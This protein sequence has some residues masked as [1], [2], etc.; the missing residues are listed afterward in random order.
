M[1]SMLK[2]I[3]I[4]ITSSLSH[5]PKNHI[6]Y[7]KSRNRF[8]FFKQPRTTC[9]QYSRLDFYSRATV[10]RSVTQN[11][12]AKICNFCQMG[13]LRNAMELLT[14]SQRHEIGLSTYYSVLQLCA[15]K[16]SLEDGKRVHSII[17]SNGVVIDEVLGAKLVFM[18][19]KCGDLVNAR[20]IFDEILNDNV[21][22]WNLMM[23]GYAKIDYYRE[24]L[25]LFKKMQ[26]MG[27]SGDSY[28]FTCVL[29]CFAELRKVKECKSVQGY[30]L[31]L[32]FGSNTAV[33]NSMIAAYFK[34][35]EVESA[36]NLFD[37]LT[38]R[39]VVSWNSLIS[40]CVVKG[41][42]GNGL[43]I[44]VEMLVMGVNWNLTTLVSVLDASTNIGNLSF[45][46]A[47]HAFGVK[48]CYG[49]EF[50][51]NNE[52]LY[53]YAIGGDLVNAR[54]IFD[55]ILNDKVSLWNFM[56][57]EYAKSGYY[58]ESLSLFKKMQKMGVSGDSNTFTCVLKCFAALRK[59]KECKRVHEYILKLGFGSNTAVVTSMIAAYFKFGEVESALN[60][61]DE[62]TD[63]DVVSW[64]SV[65]S[66]CAVNGFSKNVVE[67][68][69]Q[70]L[71]MGVNW[72]LNTLVSVLDASANIG[73]LSIGRALHAF[74]VKA[75]FGEEF[76]FNNRLL[77]MYSKIRDYRG[78]LSLFK[79]MQMMGVLG[80]SDMFCCAFKCFAELGKLEECKRVHGYILK[81]GFGSNTAVVNSMIV[82][83]FKF[84]EVESACNLFDELTDRD[85]FSW[86]SMINGCIMN[87]L[88][89]NGLEIFIEMLV[90]GINWDLTILVSV[91]DASA[92]IG[93]LSIGRALHA[94]GVKAR[95]GEEFWFNYRLLSMYSKIR[96]YRGSLSLFKKMQMMGVSGNSYMFT[97][98]FKCF[99]E[100]GKVEEC[101]RV[102]G[103]ILKLGFGSNTAV[104]NWMIMAYFKFG[105]V[106]SACNLFDELTDRDV[107]SWSYM[108]NG[109]I[110]N[111]ISK[112]VVEIFVQMLVMGV[113]WDLNTLV[114]V[115]DASANI[116]N[117]SIGRA[118]H[119]FG[120]KACFGEEFWFNNRLLY[121]Y[122][123]IRDYR[124]SLS[125]FKKMQM[126]G[127]SGDS[128]MFTCVF[129]CFAELGKV[130][131]CKMVHGYILKLG[132]G[133]NTAVV[134]SMIVAYFKFGEVESAC[135]LFDE[136]TDRDVFSW[137]SMINGCI[138]NGLSGNGIE[139][140]VEML[141]MGIN[142]DLTT[143]VSVLDAS[144]NI[145]NLSIGRALHA[146]GVKAY[147]G[148]EFWFNN[149][150]LF[151]YGKC[152]DLVNA[153][154]IFDEIL[155][156]KVYLWNFMMSEYAKI[157]YYKGS[158]S[159]F[160]KMQKMGVLGES[161]TFTC[162][163]NCFAEL[164]KFEECRRVHGYIVKL[165][166]GSNTAVVNSMIAAY[167]RFGD[168]ES[169]QNLFYE[170]TDRDVISWTSMINGC[171][172]NDLSGNGLEI[173]VE[174]L[175][176]GVNWDLI[177]LV[178]VLEASANIGNLSF[179]RA[180]H[181]FG[182]KACFDEEVVHSCIIKSG[183]GSNLPVA[184]ALMNM[185][186]KCGSVEEARLVFSHTLA[187]DIVS[188]NTMIGCY[189]QNSLPNEALELFSDMQKQLKPDDI[190]M[191]CVLPACAGLAALDKG[192]EIH[193][194]I[195]RR[196]YFSDLRAACALVD[197]YAKCG[198]LVLARLLFDMI[199][200]KDLISWTVMIAGYSMH[201]FGNEAISTF[202]K[203]RIA[204]IEPDESS[205][206]AILNA[207][208]HSELLHEGWR[209]F[210][211][212][213]NECGIE[214]KLEHYACMVDL[215][216][217]A[218]NL[219]KAYKFIES[220]PI[221]PD[222]TIWGALLSGCR[223]HH[224]VKL[225]EKV[226]EH[227]FELEPDN[228]MY[229]VVLA[230]V[231]AEAEKW[232]EVKRLQEKLR[233]RRFKQDP[234]CSW[235]EVGGKLNIFDAGNTKHP[236]AKRIDALL[237]KL[238]LQMKNGDYSI[239]L[240]NED[241][242]E[243]EV[244]QCGHSEKLAMAFGILNLPSGRTVRVTKNRR[245]CRDCH[246]MGK[247]MSKTTKREILLRDSNRFH[248]F[249]D[250]L[251]SC[252]GFW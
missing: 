169:A 249:K 183:M 85:V 109:C 247:F 141:V 158:L 14:T 97:C 155:N 11:Q 129:K 27:V 181:A 251:C 75:C 28:T 252:R 122:S 229:Y 162:V 187:K 67:I 127:V 93:N 12:N 144:A 203:M 200:Q 61:F 19:V 88:S 202:N 113:N 34:F 138:M 1:S 106:E 7:S 76:W 92:N 241:D 191:A 51:F 13:N 55:E 105:E 233:N 220:M 86:N 115:L 52:L 182:V 125:L 159:L 136:L 31:K 172:V 9:L 209:F 74:G 18:Y 180:L 199:P 153:R 87:G 99:A 111:G 58:R 62:L 223:I 177:T 117:L 21:F 224:D 238:S 184:N 235:I 54:Q 91:L 190:T 56:M 71:V 50:W 15:E 210:N 242:M 148:E 38:D 41:L 83:Y 98:V 37:E 68:F 94:F 17:I 151:M 243:K 24:S 95:Y 232:E 166:F 193:G 43:E 170:L 119:A 116:G 211:F 137:N 60:L 32:G 167:F 192:R 134:N 147:Y 222:A 213:R 226:A 216:S 23:S 163:F 139:I 246:E 128:Y 146:F 36:L 112:N 178:S 59:V 142:W 16:N 150:L 176:M 45:G 35:G 2:T 217:R 189:S 77:Y 165:G 156:D 26:K 132:F 124:G 78:S 3:P 40:G 118:L 248:H 130:E 154:Q 123:K 140:F 72:D 63:R 218:G 53:M 73:N 90:M 234:G 66:E 5:N 161:Y 44:F 110:M 29:K 225:A 214:P 84:G 205:F 228:T 227:L 204:G 81:L 126:M 207:C 48:A 104:V 145:G 196:G 188:W 25:S 175:V 168:V 80:D 250:G 239:K 160:K 206:A 33:V 215:L 30:I 219:S 82:A 79:K 237:R 57:S 195:L 89:G 133:S 42:F 157:G 152:G 245:V 96:D 8:I 186:A 49:E 194:H 20:G 179:G 47:L 208:S 244:I 22:L 143:L 65:I 102:H 121:M 198:L 149:R 164:G 135:N 201:G 6:N 69:V 103:Y 171:I 10:T 39:D 212:M 70:M 174:M 4:S 101:K 230:N 221:E 64:N 131:E 197:M 173:F 107:F 100:L 108:I 236:Q 185:Y 46:R 120:V 231:Y 114:S 240:I